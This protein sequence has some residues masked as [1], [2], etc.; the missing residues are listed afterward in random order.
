M[1][2]LRK[3]TKAS[4]FTLIELLIVVAIIAILAAIAIPNFLAAQTRSKVS[5]CK[6]DMRSV[7]TALESYYVDNNTYPYYNNPSAHFLFISITPSA[8]S[9]SPEQELT[10]PVSYIT[11][12]PLD[13][14]GFSI[15]GSFNY[16]FR[17]SPFVEN[18][19]DPYNQINSKYHGGWILGSDGPGRTFNPI[20]TDIV[21]PNDGGQLGTVANTRIV[22]LYDPTNGTISPGALIRSQGGSTP[23]F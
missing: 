19:A 4:G 1:N 16:P 9:P 20:Y 5:R 3:T 7:A 10:S 17:Y 6:A 21:A 14:F 13:Q 22:D 15:G 11:S 23:N 2:S 18:I 12:I 8:G